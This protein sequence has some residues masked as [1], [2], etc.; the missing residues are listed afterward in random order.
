MVA[1]RS[2]KSLP[3]LACCIQLAGSTFSFKCDAF[4]LER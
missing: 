2:M 3:E 1:N 4:A